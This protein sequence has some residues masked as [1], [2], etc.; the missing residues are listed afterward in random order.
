MDLIYYVLE[1]LRERVEHVLFNLV[2]FDVF[3]AWFKAAFL[4]IYSHKM[5]LHR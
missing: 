3:L 4:R 1:D 2:S 5:S